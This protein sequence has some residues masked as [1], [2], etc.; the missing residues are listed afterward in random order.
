MPKTFSKC[1]LHIGTEKTG[2]TTLQTF[3]GENRSV[4][5]DRGYY[6]PV[7]LSPYRVLANHERL[8][9]FALD[10]LK[11]TDDLRLAA[12]VKS[13]S[14]VDLHREVVGAAFRDEVTGL[15]NAPRYLVLSNE[16]CHSRLTTDEEVSRLHGLLAEYCNETEVIVYLR[17]QHELATSLYT[18]AM[19]AGYFDIAILPE[20]TE[21]GSG[22]WVGRQYFDYDDLTQRWARVFGLVN[23]KPHIYS[24]SEL[25]SGNVV[26]D[27]LHIIGCPLQGINPPS[28]RNQSISAQL[29][30]VLNVVNRY[31]HQNPGSIPPAWRAKF[32]NL[33]EVSSTAPGSKPLRSD[34]IRFYQEFSASN[35]QVRRNFFRTR[36]SLFTV[37]FASYPEKTGEQTSELDA[38]VKLIIEMV[39]SGLS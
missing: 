32:L 14:D 31:S 37:D 28:D 15:D 19:R 7:T 35:E 16:H 20:F 26:L 18:Q 21:R 23:I 6:V 38:M 1:Y 5:R 12:G 39:Q 29:Q 11:L 13:A 2:T 30:A 33:L 22:T 24:R 25:F 36:M 4:L 8:T 3:L 10:N 9:T 17:P 34:A 27:F